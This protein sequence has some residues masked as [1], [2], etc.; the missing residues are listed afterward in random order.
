MDPDLSALDETLAERGVDGYV[1]D[2]DSEDADQYYLSGFDAPDPF[3]TLY[4]GSAGP[5]ARAA[6]RP[7]NGSP[8][9]GT[10]TS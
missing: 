9:T 5:N 8:T 4:D 10:T 3:L 6:A 7:S 1:I 2:A